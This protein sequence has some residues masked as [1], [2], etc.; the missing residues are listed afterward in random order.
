MRMGWGMRELAVVA[1]MA[2]LPGI[3]SVHAVQ[4][5]APYEWDDIMHAL[6]VMGLFVTVDA[7]LYLVPNLTAADM[8]AIV[9]DMDIQIARDFAMHSDLIIDAVKSGPV[10]NTGELGQSNPEIAAYK[11]PAPWRGAYVAF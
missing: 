11:W 7:D 6:D 9:T 5:D 1:C 4:S 10:G 3:G 8:N 2:A